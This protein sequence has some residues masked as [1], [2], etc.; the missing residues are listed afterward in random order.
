MGY[1]RMHP[2]SLYQGNGKRR[3]LGLAASQSSWTRVPDSVRD[4]V[5]KSMVEKHLKKT[6]DL[7][8]W[9]P[10]PL[11]H[12]HILSHRQVHA[13]TDTPSTSSSKTC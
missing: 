1:G 8:L 3:T 13:Y 7:K 6:R 4:H 12:T 5:P 2:S 10:H 11:I 9:S